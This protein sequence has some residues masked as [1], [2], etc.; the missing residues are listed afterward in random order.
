[1]SRILFICSAFAPRNIIGAVRPSKLAKYMVRMGHEVT[2]VSPEV[3]EGEP[4]DT[5][6]ES[7]EL[8][9]VRRITIPYSG[10]YHKVRGAYRKS[11]GGSSSSGGSTGFKQF[12][13][14]AFTL[15]ND[16][17]W[18]RRVKAALRGLK[19]KG[20]FD[21]VISSYPNVGAH[22][23]AAWARKRGL[24]R[25]WVA[26]F[27]DPMVYDWQNAPQRR[28]NAFLQRRFERGSDA[29]TTVSKDLMPKFQDAARAGKLHWLPNGFD[30]DDLVTSVKTISVFTFSEEPQKLILAY[31]GGL[32][33]GL[34]DFSSL[35]QALQE[36]RSDGVAD[37]LFYYAG[38]DEAV[39]RNSAQKH[40]IEGIIRSFGVLERRDALMMQQ[41][42]DAVVICSLNTKRDKGIMTGKVFDCLLLGRPLVA[43]INGDAPGSELGQ[44]LRDVGAG[45]VYEEAAHEV[46]FLAL[47]AFLARLSH[48]KRTG[49]RVS[50]Q[51][52]ENKKA[53]YTYEKIATRMAFL[54][55]NENNV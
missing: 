12:A 37:A 21:A 32:Y 46:D 22:L 51:M 17:L 24:A 53:Q 28:A 26:D 1:M 43:V 54:S 30:L 11:A 10:A 23:A 35:F 50:F 44:L 25:R 16:L 41:K 19:D 9:R 45:V 18:T 4:K 39:L 15:L 8:L 3:P 48:E 40:G 52:D 14:F 49:G 13:R 20:P 33:G 5:L 29:V 42:A 27:R 47:K 36:L 38:R 55:L 31:A 6:L 34:R 2:V 7:P